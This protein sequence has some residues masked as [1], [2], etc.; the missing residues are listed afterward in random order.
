VIYAAP[1]AAFEERIMKGTIDAA[2]TMIIQGEALR[3]IGVVPGS[4]STKGLVVAAPTG[5]GAKFLDLEV[6]AVSKMSVDQNGAIF[7][8]ASLAVNVSVL[9]YGATVATDTGLANLFKLTVTNGIAFTMSDP[10]NP[11]TGRIATF[12][13]LNSSGGAMG[14]VTWGAA[15]KLDATGFVSPAN[16][17]R[18]TISFYYDGTNWVQIGP[19]SG[20]I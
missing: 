11:I 8:G 17:K 10:T 13:I 20:D 15:F 9:T 18:K 3:P 14:V 16:G 1:G 4:T 19:T 5:Y 2:S 6:N 7:C 12:D